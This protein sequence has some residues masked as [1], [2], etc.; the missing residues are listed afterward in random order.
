M[1]GRFLHQVELSTR[2]LKE[3]G[4]SSYDADLDSSC[5][6]AVH[7]GSSSTT[8]DPESDSGCELQPGSSCE[9]ETE[10]VLRQGSSDGELGHGVVDSQPLLS[11][12]G[13]PS[14]AAVIAV[15]SGSRLVPLVSHKLHVDV[16]GHSE[17]I[18]ISSA[19]QP[20]HSKSR[21]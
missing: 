19:L 12:A 4:S 7:G 2:G 5:E 9:V 15:S 8:V 13:V 20:R 18:V 21:R 14:D 11:G 17:P 6:I 1:L 16:L 3:A 10:S